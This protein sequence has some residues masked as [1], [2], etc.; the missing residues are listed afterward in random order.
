MFKKPMNKV[1]SAFATLGLL[2]SSLVFSQQ[3]SRAN[4]A[5]EQCYGGFSPVFAGRVV[6]TLG[7][8]V[9]EASVQ[10]TYQIDFGWGKQHQSTNGYTAA[11]GSYEMC[12]ILNPETQ[13][14]ASPVVG[15]DVIFSISAGIDPSITLKHVELATDDVQ[16]IEAG[17][18]CIF[19][20]VAKQGSVF[21][22][23][24]TSQVE[25]TLN[26]TFSAQLYSSVLVADE[27]EGDWTETFHIGFAQTSPDGG[28]DIYGMQSGEYRIALSPNETDL[29]MR[30]AWQVVIDSDSSP[31]V[32]RLSN[33]DGGDA[34]YA[35]STQGDPITAVAGKF[36]LSNPSA[37]AKFM[38]T[39]GTNPLDSQHLAFPDDH[40]RVLPSGSGDQ[41]QFI[42]DPDC[43]WETAS[44]AVKQNCWGGMDLNSRGEYL[45]PWEN[46][47]YLFGAHF[48][49]NSQG[50]QTYF[51]LE[52]ENSEI[53]NIWRNSGFAMGDEGSQVFKW[54]EIDIVNNSSGVRNGLTLHPHDLGVKLANYESGDFWV[55]G[56]LCIF[57]GDCN[58]DEMPSGQFN[59]RGSNVSEIGQ[60]AFPDAAMLGIT[61]DDSTDGTD[62][63]LQLLIDA[64]GWT[65]ANSVRT[66]FAV[67]CAGP[68]GAR[69]F[70]AYEL[71]G[72]GESKIIGESVNLQ[73][74]TLD[75]AQIVG[76]VRGP[77]GEAVGRSSYDFYPISADGSI[78]YFVDDYWQNL[79]IQNYYGSNS[80]HFGKFNLSA[81]ATGS[82]AVTFSVEDGNTNLS[83]AIGKI[84]LDV[85]VSN[86]GT[87]VSAK[88]GNSLSV[89]PTIDAL[90]API[91]VTLNAAN[92]IGTMLSQNGAPRSYQYFQVL[93][94]DPEGNIDWN[95]G[96]EYFNEVRNTQSYAGGAVAFYLPQ[97]QYRISLPASA[98]NPKTDIDVWVDSAERA[99]RYL[100]QTGS[101]ACGD[102]TISNWTF[103]YAEPN[104]RG[105]VTAGGTAVASQ[106]NIQKRNSSGWWE[107]TGDYIGTSDG[108]FAARL[109]TSGYY[110]LEI[111]PRSWS[112]SGQQP[113]EGYVQSFGYIK[114]DSSKRLCIVSSDTDF[115]AEL[116]DCT[117]NVS[118]ELQ[119]A[120]ALDESNLTI[121]VLAATT[122]GGELRPASWSGMDIRETT[123]NQFMGESFWANTNTNGKAFINLPESQGLTRFFEI[124]IRPPWNGNGLILASKV[125]KF[126]TIGDG[127]VYAATSDTCG[128]T[129]ITEV[130]NVELA[131]GNVSGRIKTSD[132]QNLPTNANAY[133]ELRMWGDTCPDC[134]D[135]SNTWGWKW[136]SNGLNNSRNGTFGGDL[137]PGMYLI[138][139]STWRSNY[140]PGSAIIR[141]GANEDENPWCLV[142]A[143]AEVLDIA[144]YNNVESRLDDVIAGA[145]SSQTA[146]VSDCD[147]LSDPATS[148]NVLLKAPNISG[149]ITDPNGA[150]IRNAWG[151]IYK[152]TGINDW[153]REYVA[154]INIQ[155]GT[156]VGR[157]KLPTSGTT[158]YGLQFEQPQRQEGSKFTITLTCTSSG[159]I[160]ESDGQSSNSLSLA[161]PAP[162]FIGRICSPDSVYAIPASDDEPGSDYSCDAVK[163][164]NMNVQRW[165]GTYWQWGNIWASTNNRGE[166]SLNID[167]AGS[168]RLTAY[169]AWS[170]PKGVETNIEFD[171]APDVD[172][173]LVALFD[174][175]DDRDPLTE[176]ILD[177]E[178]LGPNLSGKLSFN[179]DSGT[180]AMQYA[181]VSAYLQCESDC[182]T[183]WEER[184]AWTSAD[185][186]GNYR[187][188]LPSDGYWDVWA[189]AN[190]SV[191]PKPPVHMVALVENG[192]VTEWGYAATVTSD[193]DPNVGEINFDALP[194][195][196]SITISGTTEI[197]IVKF[198][199]R[200]GDYYV[201][202]LTTYTS[203]G[204]TNT[205]STRVPDGEYTLEVLKSSREQSLGFA[206]VTADGSLKSV[207]IAVE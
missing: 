193:F 158:T 202:A 61:C 71:D 174:S 52:I 154:G 157:V 35:S 19:D 147:P 118:R 32:K 51:V 161:Y 94:F 44:D 75:A 37:N 46:G 156:F 29:I 184:S 24:G 187:L 74:L 2:L 160:N 141:V 68:L 176:G 183:N 165:N 192:E 10:A 56:Y 92:I 77:S 23:R 8:A 60:I 106:V 76:L 130:F 116:I 7:N 53:L 170:N 54:T 131:E 47:F 3:L 200:N 20:I 140:A 14:I 125:R 100:S 97:G 162:N 88:Y 189:Y 151:Q 204:S 186:T 129:P 171:M 43:T 149:T 123:T 119:S 169:P 105:T 191:S 48:G 132:N 96:Y 45:L 172:G 84:R 4:E 38:L 80:V 98:G 103:R 50:V 205:V 81:F 153:D 150:V 112:D 145:V 146:G 194:A 30:S 190:P 144:E 109:D 62:P 49:Y 136:T 63:E 164:T 175:A 180:R 206:S 179:S 91:E 69:V 15:T 31:E 87:I 36:E 137:D 55:T 28:F 133:A 115:D 128:E 89:T 70:S 21:Q 117:G 82:Y 166:F 79:Q 199:N 135:N 86:D 39:D 127:Y 57:D 159:C 40:S 93:K 120:F 1:T 41:I 18:P 148:L 121:R 64:S 83:G 11:D 201:D 152:V 78:D 73:S 142:A 27:Q 177:I 207:S 22:A 139:A 6:D 12:P 196:L 178:L 16:C 67:D 167:E 58:G 163:F 168:Y 102:S 124:T 107:G 181:G 108:V 13:E 138:K 155:S 185:R 9:P 104:L 59:L 182:P 101:D 90:A 113:L 66:K 99:C 188:R 42:D 173:N 126:C 33:W 110:R 122:S 195:N 111:Q 95:D 65:P 26:V 134:F 114:V 143:D 5:Q 198:R 25:P 197:R 203:G 72:F 17:G 85:V 34:A